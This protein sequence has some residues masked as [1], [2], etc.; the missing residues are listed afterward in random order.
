MEIDMNEVIKNRKGF[1]KIR[2]R[3]IIILV[4]AILVMLSILTIK[5]P[6]L[7]VQWYDSGTYTECNPAKM[8]RYLEK[9][10]VIKFPENMREVKAA[11]SGLSWDSYSFFIIKFTDES[12]DV[13]KFVGNA[14]LYPYDSTTDDRSAPYKS[15]PEW[16][17]S[18]INKGETANMSVEG[19]YNKKLGSHIDVYIDTL[20]E[21]NYV[22]YLSGTYT[23]DLD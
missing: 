8:V 9:R 6:K 4:F 20:D 2:W 18:P 13:R 3:K 10:Y 19:N 21:K 1:R 11:K 16:W 7:F 15:V 17:T 22:V 12:S 14:T 23:S 5:L